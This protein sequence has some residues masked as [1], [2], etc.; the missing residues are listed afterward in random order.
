MEGYKAIELNTD[1][2]S[3]GERS[4]LTQCQALADM[5]FTYVVSCQQYGIDKRSGHAR[6]QDILRL[7]TMYVQVNFL[8]VLQGSITFN[9]CLYFQ[10]VGIHHS[11][12][13][14]LMRLK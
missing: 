14:I 13:H 4:L 9:P 12:W 3:K 6:A 7:M 8:V 10:L 5:K 2:R 1:D 11:V